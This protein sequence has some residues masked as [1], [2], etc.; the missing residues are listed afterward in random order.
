MAISVLDVRDTF[1]ASRVGATV[2]ARAARW[3]PAP[4]VAVVAAGTVSLVEALALLAGALTGLDGLLTSTSR[5]AG[6][7]VAL[8]LV[9]LAGWIV[10]CTCSAATLVDAAGRRSVLA[11]AYAELGLIGGLGIAAVGT[12][13]LPVTVGGL[14]L[15]GILLLSVAVP[16]VKILLAETASAQHWVAS[17]PRMRPRR[18]DPVAAHRLL[19]TVTVTGIGLALTALAVLAPTG[20]EAGAGAGA[21]AGGGA[22]SP[23]SQH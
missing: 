13:F 9:G 20:A 18:P 4:P 3:P 10:A 17:G 21:G 14:P 5:P 19:C 16:V 2:A 22:G 1:A 11:V 23:V 6:W 7:V 15:P 12:A 8:A